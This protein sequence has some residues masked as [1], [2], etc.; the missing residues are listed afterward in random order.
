[1]AKT[2]HA[3]AGEHKRLH[4]TAPALDKTDR[5]ERA[6]MRTAEAEARTEHA[7]TRTEMAET[8]TEQAETRAEMAETRTEQ[9][10]TRTEQ[11]ETRSE[12]LQSILE[13]AMKKEI[14][15]SEEIP[16]NFLKRLALPGIS[17]GG[18]ALDHLTGRQRQIL[19]LIAQGQNTKTIA[20]TL[21]LSPKTVEY[22]RMKLMDSLNVHDVAGLVKFAIRAGVI[23]VAGEEAKENEPDVC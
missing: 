16:V 12:Q 1:M 18:S 14:A 17:A 23:E 15:L 8:R 21:K 7:E 3:G 10:L 6:E 9:A 5:V 11:A 19:K 2:A 4:H 20:D 13:R 22:H